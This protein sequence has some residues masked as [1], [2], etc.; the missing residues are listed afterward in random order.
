VAKAK[1]PEYPFVP[2]TNAYLIPG[3]FFSIRLTNGRYACGRV[4]ANRW[5]YPSGPGS[6]TTF[7]VGLMDWSGDHPATADDL[8]DCRV[9]EQGYADVGIV[10]RYEAQIDGCR[11]LEADGIAPDPTAQGMYGLEVLRILA[12]QYFGTVPPTAVRQATG[13][14]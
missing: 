7:R 13:Q 14:S 9:L 11:P 1:V 6:R 4:L 3:Q 10:P 12:H 5:S 8:A 2:R